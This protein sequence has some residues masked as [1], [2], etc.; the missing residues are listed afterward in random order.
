MIR[1][2][3]WHYSK[4]A[5]Q[6]GM[7]EPDFDKWRKRQGLSMRTR[8]GYDKDEVLKAHED[9]KA[10]GD[11]LRTLWEAGQLL[12]MHPTQ[13]YEFATQNGYPA[14]ESDI[15]GRLERIIEYKPV[16]LAFDAWIAADPSR[17]AQMDKRR[18]ELVQKDTA[19]REL[20]ERLDRDWAER[21]RT[22]DKEK[23]LLEKAAHD[24]GMHH[25]EFKR[26]CKQNHQHITELPGRVR[27]VHWG[28]V[29]RAHDAWK[30]AGNTHVPRETEQEKRDEIQAQVNHLRGR[31]PRGHRPW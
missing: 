11:K 9:W 6:L 25:M 4:A 31:V 18:E 16:K 27:Y 10:D 5:Q 8:S 15:T 1:S 3:E 19:A 21:Q 22:F 13:V 7:S 14:P 28:Q 12:Q 29:K 20:R 23:V 26:W 2:E 30:A 17:R 24:L